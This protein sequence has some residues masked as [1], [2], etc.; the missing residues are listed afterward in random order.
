MTPPVLAIIGAGSTGKA[1]A[2]TAVASGLEVHLF[3]RF[4]IDLPPTDG[5]RSHH[6][7]AVWG[8]FAGPRVA[9]SCDDLP[10]ILEPDAVLL[11]HGATDPT[12]PF[13]GSTLPG[14]ITGTGI[15]TLLQRWH[16]L[17]ARRFTIIGSGPR[18]QHVSEVL[19][20]AGGEVSLMVDVSEIRSFE[21]TG[22]GQV[23]HARLHGRTVETDMVVIALEPA[24]DLTFAAMAECELTF[25]TQQSHW[26][27]SRDSQCRTTNRQIWIAGGAAG[28]HA[29]ADSAAEGAY[30]A[31]AIAASFLLVDTSAVER[32]RPTSIPEDS[33]G[34][35]SAVSPGRV[36]QPWIPQSTAPI[37]MRAPRPAMAGDV[38]SS[39]RLCV[40][41]CEEV[42]A[43]QIDAAIT[44]GASSLN[45]LKRR[46]RAGMGLCQGA[47]CLN[48]MA[49]ML[50]EALNIPLS[51]LTPMT[52]R[53]P[54]GG[55]TLQALA[56][57]SPAL[58]PD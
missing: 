44:A 4:P 57:S 38:N 53:P 41:R 43:A 19:K 31:A 5:I 18:G 17:P 45:D 42:T 10:V 32:I 56:A 23:E 2:L 25:D 12:V 11:A 16:L 20:H 8:L 30:A 35:Q 47:Y 46:T 51:D 34:S 13:P 55:I 29:S 49:Q 39:G 6:W 3:D 24:P 48:V 36:R 52:L 37:D 7:T 26:R 1:A 9:A 27:V 28:A 15:L 33:P 54:V 14:V 21:V 22:R 58:G 50:S 40:C